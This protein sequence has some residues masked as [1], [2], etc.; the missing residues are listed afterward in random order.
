MGVDLRSM[1]SGVQELCDFRPEIP[2][3]IKKSKQE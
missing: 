1:E 3:K 2:V